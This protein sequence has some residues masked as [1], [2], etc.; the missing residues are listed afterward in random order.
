MAIGSAKRVLQKD[1]RPSGIP[2]Y[3]AREVARL[4]AQ[5][6]IEQPLFISEEQY[7]RLTIDDSGPQ[8]GDLMVS[9]VGTL[10]KIYLVPE[11]QR[12]YYKD[13]SVIR[14]SAWQKRV[15][16][17][18]LKIYLE[19]DYAR[20]QM[21]QHSQG[22]TVDTISISAAGRYL[23]ALPPLRE[24]RA[25]AARY[26]EILIRIQELEQAKKRLLQATNKIKVRLLD[27]A[28]TGNLLPQEVKRQQQGNW[29]FSLP[30]DW[31][32]YRGSRCFG[33]KAKKNSSS[34][35]I[36]YIDID[37]IDN[38]VCQVTLPKKMPATQAPKRA[39]HTVQEGNVLFSLVRPYLKNIAY[40]SADLEGC[41]AS[42]AF[43]ICHPSSVL[44]GRYAYY[45]MQSSY[46]V[47]GLNQ[48]M[49]GDSSPAINQADVEAWLYP[50][51]PISEQ[52][53]LVQILDQNFDQIEKL[54][55]NFF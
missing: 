2:F 43:F 54:E 17:E 13:A 14:L 47:S 5:E 18:Y 25:I 27:L 28:M 19:S 29:P 55:K 22:S 37:A 48:L 33:K 51:P 41:V 52:Q 42:N 32:W 39:R 26:A 7:A 24:Q 3:R 4:A 36:R 21:I 20:C 10:G 15:S 50:I 9:A 34:P 46:V 35:T 8:A 38:Q 23:I 31:N 49:R 40:I 53:R 45:L 30:E 1:W 16:S 44:L 6:E 11:G 12:F